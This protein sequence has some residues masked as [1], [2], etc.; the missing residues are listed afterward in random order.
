MLDEDRLEE[1]GTLASDERLEERVAEGGGADGDGA[2]QPV[3]P[4]TDGRGHEEGNRRHDRDGPGGAE[5]GDEAQ[6]REQA[7]ELGR[8]DGADDR[9]IERVGQVEA[10]HDGEGDH[11]GDS[12]AG[13]RE[14]L[15]GTRRHGGQSRARSYD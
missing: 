4:G 6:R 9:P 5:L 7:V 1:V 11:H 2:D 12:P 3:T 8:P 13:E 15:Y 10:H 14:A